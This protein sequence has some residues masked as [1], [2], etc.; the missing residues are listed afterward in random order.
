MSDRLMVVQEEVSLADIGVVLEVLFS[1]VISLHNQLQ[2][3]TSEI[4][5]LDEGQSGLSEISEKVRGVSITSEDFFDLEKII[6]KWELSMYKQP[7]RVFLH[8]EQLLS[9]VYILSH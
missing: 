9:L 3:L 5:V 7:C 1:L 6:S 8:Q 2:D 4:S